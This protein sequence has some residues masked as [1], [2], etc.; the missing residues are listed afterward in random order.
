MSTKIYYKDDADL[1]L[2]EGKKLRGMM[3]WLK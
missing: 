1:S 2:L 3:D